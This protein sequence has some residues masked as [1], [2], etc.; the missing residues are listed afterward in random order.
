LAAKG[1]QNYG[2]RA[3]IAGFVIRISGVRAPRK[4]KSSIRIATSAGLALLVL[5]L[6]CA[7]AVGGAPSD[8]LTQTP[9]ASPTLPIPTAPTVWFPATNTLAPLPTRFN[10]PTPEQ[11]P[12]VGALIFS[13]SFSDPS[14]WQTAASDQASAIVT[15][16]RIS[17]AVRQPGLGMIS[18]RNE[19]ILRDFYAE[20]TARPS[21]CAGDDDYGLL[22][23]AASPNDYYRIALTCN[24]TVRVDR[25][26]GGESTPVISPAPSGDVP[27]GPPGEV[28]IGIWASGPDMRVF[29][30][31][32]YQFAINDPLFPGGTLGLFAR[33][34]GPNA[35][36]VTFSDLNVSEVS[37]AS[38][39][40][41]LTPSLTAKPSR[42]PRATP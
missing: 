4:I 9:E 3:E 14:V 13:D 30:N 10:T 27:R 39:T 40:P 33:S 32:H 2:F 26:R 38:P 1:R 29:L 25:V 20:V 36:T 16:D 11:R 31:D 23:R 34:Q 15:G 24:G 18:L 8:I 41:T 28:R 19:P 17:L 12:G 7:P 42:T 5:C 6:A 21:L 35:V 22:Y 37:Y